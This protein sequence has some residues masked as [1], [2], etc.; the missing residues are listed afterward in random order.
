MVVRQQ[1]MQTLVLVVKDII[2][3]FRKSET[4]LIL[5]SFKSY[6]SHPENQYLTKVFLNF[7]EAL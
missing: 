2:V 5:I 4:I 1:T 7:K 6:F 3:I